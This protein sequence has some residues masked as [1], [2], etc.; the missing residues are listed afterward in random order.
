ML[1][2]ISLLV[3]LFV[4]AISN[5]QT[6]NDK[7]KILYG[8]C[9]KTELETAPYDAWFKK[10]YDDYTPNAATVQAI[11]KESLKD[12]S[13]K[14]FFGTW[15]G[16][17]KREVPRFMKLLDAAGFPLS[18]VTLIATGGGD[19]LYK[20]SPQHE[21]AGLGIYKVPTFI[22]YRNGKEIHRIVEFP[23][24]SL[25]KDMLVIVQGKSYTP[26]YAAFIN[27]DKWI[28]DGTLLDSNISIR[29]LALQIKPLVNSEYELNSLGY[30]LLAQKK[31][32]EAI[33]V[34]QMNYF[35]YPQSSN[36][37][38][39]LGEGYY[40]KGDYENAV[41]YLENALVKNTDPKAWRG[42]LDI[43]YKAKSL[44]R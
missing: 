31:M 25:E 12:I 17:S 13:V 21:E 42:I 37:A 40:E 32:K 43:L 24:L 29:S 34:F 4:S 23:A 38:S 14:I 28:A 16:D 11:K 18:K 27:V 39:S 35:L 33:S 7:P 15:C 22:F 8:V 30:M 19:S 6:T 9:T 36:V 20:Q 26:N 1:K 5:A 2:N 41:Y 44:E 3:L 10:N